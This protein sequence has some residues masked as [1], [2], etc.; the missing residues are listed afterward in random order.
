[1]NKLVWRIFNQLIDV[2]WMHDSK[3]LLFLF[4]PFWGKLQCQFSG[5]SQQSPGYDPNNSIGFHWNLSDG[6]VIG[7]DIFLSFLCFDFHLIVSF[8][9]FGYDCNRMYDK[10]SRSVGLI[11]PLDHRGLNLNKRGV[12][13][14]DSY[15][16]NSNCQSNTT[17]K[18]KFC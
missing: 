12:L 4:L 10:T 7:N 14:T 3:L 16:N 6:V 9:T 18:N 5:P 1:M 17:Y 13:T 2:S 11:Q 15:Y 8:C